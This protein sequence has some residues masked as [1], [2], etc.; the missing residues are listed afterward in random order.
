M[1]SKLKQIINKANKRDIRWA[2]IMTNIDGVSDQ[3]KDDVTTVFQSADMG[4]IVEDIHGKFGVIHQ[5]IFP[6]QNYISQMKVSQP[7]NILALHTLENILNLADST[8]ESQTRMLPADVEPTPKLALLDKPWRVV[9][10][11]KEGV[12]SMW[13][14]LADIQ[15]KPKI[16]LCFIGPSEGGKSS[17][18]NSAISEMYQRIVSFAKTGGS[19]SP[20]TSHYEEYLL[21]QGRHGKELDIKLM[22]TMGLL[23]HDRGIL[24]DDAITVLDGKVANTTAFNPKAPLPRSDSRQ[25]LAERMHLLALVVN[26]KEFGGESCMYSKEIVTIIQVIIDTAKS[27]PR[28]IPCVILVTHMDEVC[29]YV[30][31]NPTMMYQSQAVK[32]CLQTIQEEFK[33]PIVDILPIINYQNDTEVDW[34]KAAFVLHALNHMAELAKD[35]ITGALVGTKKKGWFW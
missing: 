24:A 34:R 22:D 12:E 32:K 6:V 13:T 26:G 30:L 20:V 7:M 5:N 25:N 14:D 9:E 33:I 23:E 11:T 35:Y 15:S 8:L 31:Q 27:H 21:R 4:A 3:V 10:L 1:V 29:E 19:G 2:V 17:F 18:I 28:K 16:R